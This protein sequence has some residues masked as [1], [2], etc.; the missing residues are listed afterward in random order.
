MVFFLVIFPG[1]WQS[2]GRAL[3]HP[4]LQMR[5]R[6][7]KKGMER[8]A[9]HS[10]DVLFADRCVSS[11]CCKVRQSSCWLAQS[12]SLAQLFSPK[13]HEGGAVLPGPQVSGIGRSIFRPIFSTVL[14]NCCCRPVRSGSRQSSSHS[15]SNR[16]R[17]WSGSPKC[18]LLFFL[19]VWQLSRQWF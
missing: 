19:F 11:Q 17:K 18:S 7:R 12:F 2:K 5:K 16:R 13:I 9:Q 10:S 8:G 4:P 3:P 14:M 15:S 6:L 1:S